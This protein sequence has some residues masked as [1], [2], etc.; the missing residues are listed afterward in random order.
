M[1]QIAIVPIEND[2]INIHS[3]NVRFV[4]VP[5]I[6]FDGNFDNFPGTYE[7]ISD[8][9]N[10]GK[11][12]A[13]V[14]SINRN[15]RLDEASDYMCISVRATGTIGLRVAINS[16]Y[17]WSVATDMTAPWTV[18]DV[19]SSGK[20]SVVGWN[21]RLQQWHTVDFHDG[22]YANTKAYDILP[23]ID[24]RAAFLKGYAAARALFGGSR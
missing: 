17:G 24:L 12:V 19:L 1:P 7:C 6:E 23:P 2:E 22:I 13:V 15:Q 11:D 14:I 20:L 5:I 16:E 9:I 18:C 8:H 21:G 10:E 3:D 4:N